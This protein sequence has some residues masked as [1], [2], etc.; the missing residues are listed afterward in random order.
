MS[1]NVRISVV[2]ATYNGARF[3]TAQLE[4]LLAALGSQ[5]E[6]VV[7]DDNSSDETRAV[8]SALRDPRIRLLPR[9]PRLGY[10]GNFARSIAASRG[11]I[12]MF[13]DQDDICLPERITKS[14]SAL[15]EKLCVCGDAVVVDD[16][17]NVIQH[18]FF[19]AR[20]ARFGAW[21]LFVRPSVIGATMA[22][23]REFVLMSLPVPEGVP[24]DM[25][26]SICAARRRELAVVRAPFILYRRHPSAASVT[27]SANTRP[28]RHILTERMQL[29]W[30]L[31][32]RGG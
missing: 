17:L 19:M 4:S 24:H 23:H 20:R 30:A 13:S 3:V 27:A 7:S 8:I 9:G 22:C 32:S 28:L 11:R 10:Q 31:I 16:T 5:D 29:G 6:I 15:E 2:M 1:D 21:Q 26:L 18:S 25:W 14:L 12:I